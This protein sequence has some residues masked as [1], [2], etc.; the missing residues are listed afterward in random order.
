METLKTDYLVIGAGA[1]GMAFVDVMLDESDAEFIIVDRHHMPGGHW[2]DAYPFVRLH[3]PSSFYGVSSTP[4]GTD[5][6]DTTGSNKGFFELASGP[7]VLSYFEQV[8]RERFLSSGRVR[9]FPMSE[10]DGDGQFHSPMSGQ[11]Y[12]VDVARRTVDGTFFNTSV[13]STH[14]RKFSTGDG[15]KCI[16]PNELPRLAAGFQHYTVVGAGKTAMDAAVWLLDNGARADAITWITPRDS[17][18]VNRATTQAGMEFFDEAIGGFA[19]QLQASAAATSVDDLF[20]RFEAKGIMLRINPDIRPTMFH[21]AT[22]STGEVEQLRRIENVIRAGRVASIERDKIIMQSGDEIPAQPDTLYIDCTA[23]AVE[24]SS[25]SK[26][27]FDGDTITVQAI[28]APLITFSAALT[29]YV[30]AHYQDDAEKNRLCSPVV[31]ADTPEQW[32]PSFVGNMTNQYA[33]SQEKE[34]N[35]WLARNRLD[36]FAKVIQAVD[37]KNTGQVATLKRLQDAI[38]PAMTNL[39]QLMAAN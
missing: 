25:D 31:L 4:L 10:F 18:L 17:W 26:P 1:V 24:F 11:R 33:W 2:N 37:R 6:I 29:A 9:Y 19:D 8:M 12:E 36:P 28:R 3:Q 34:L 13:P 27:V 38:M 30:E 23:T 15:I 21:Y 20:E 5:R 32:I 39:H 14:K 16:A 22:I 35:D 7:E